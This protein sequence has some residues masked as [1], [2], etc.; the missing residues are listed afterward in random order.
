MSQYRKRKRSRLENQIRDGIT[1][2][3]E[4]MRKIKVNG[5]LLN[6]SIPS[7]KTP[8]KLHN[9]SIFSDAKNN[10]VNFSCGCQNWKTNK[11][12]KHIKSTLLFVITNI[13][14]SQQHVIDTDDIID[15][16]QSFS[17]SEKSKDKEKANTFRPYSWTY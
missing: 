13:I 7:I 17:M 1:S 15:A 2:P 12:C 6:F 3:P 11:T 14:Q 5:G 9:T 10:K 4:L 16:L 8:D